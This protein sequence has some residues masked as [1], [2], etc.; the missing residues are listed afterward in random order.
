MNTDDIVYG[1]CTEFMVKFEDEKT[2]NNPFDE[3][4][5]RQQLNE[6]GDS[7]LVISDDEIAKVHI[8]SEEPGDVLIIQSKIRIA[9]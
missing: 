5:F 9:N 7:L 2:K 8:H 4:K 1:Y 3:T 6:F